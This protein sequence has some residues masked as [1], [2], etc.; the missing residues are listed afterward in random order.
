MSSLI[1]I[2]TAELEKLRER[3]HEIFASFDE[4]KKGAEERPSVFSSFPALRQAMNSKLLQKSDEDGIIG[5][6]TTLSILMDC[7]VFR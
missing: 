6:E 5:S 1:E 2:W 3:H 4:E 7:F